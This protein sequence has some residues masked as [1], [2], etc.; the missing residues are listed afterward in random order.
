MH[1]EFMFIWKIGMWV[2]NEVFKKS[3][4]LHFK[5]ETWGFFF[6]GS[7][8]EVIFAL[9]SISS[10]VGVQIGRELVRLITLIGLNKFLTNIKSIVKKRSFLVFQR[11]SS[12][13]SLTI[14]FPKGNLK[15]LRGRS[16][17]FIFSYN[18]KIF[19]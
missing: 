4:C 14:T 5:F 10:H 19:L 13:I 16:M 18:L 15:Q 12:A 7:V 1:I 3:K 11:L 8:N 6:L 9:W 17:P 2:L